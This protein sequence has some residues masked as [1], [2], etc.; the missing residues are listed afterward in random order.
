MS[1]AKPRKLTPRQEA[2][3][4][5]TATDR[6]R[7]L[8][9]GPKLARLVA[10]NPSASAELLLELSRREE[11]A[12]RKACTSHANTP[13]KAIWGT[14][15]IARRTKHPSPL[16]MEGRCGGDPASAEVSGDHQLS[17]P[18]APGFSQGLLGAIQQAVSCIGSW[19]EAAH[20]NA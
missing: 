20:A 16:D 10:A 13:V 7:E 9:G 11:K 3:S 14:C 15:S 8:A 2:A 17:C 5:D 6:L 4:V 19:H 18:I 1:P 12:V